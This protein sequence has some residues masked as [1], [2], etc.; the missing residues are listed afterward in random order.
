MRA[1]GGAYLPTHVREGCSAGRGL[2]VQISNPECLLVGTAGGG[3]SN[4]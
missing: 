3:A 1:V 2:I 4:G